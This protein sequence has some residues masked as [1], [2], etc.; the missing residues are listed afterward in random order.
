MYIP[1]KISIDQIVLGERGRSSYNNIE[2]L[3]QSIEDN[4]LIQ[5]LVLVPISEEVKFLKDENCKT[6]DEFAIIGT[7]KMFYGIDAGGRRY[8]A[9]RHLGITELF[10]AT[11]SDPTRPGFVLKGEDQGTPLARLM[12]EIAENLDRLERR[13][14]VAQQGLEVSTC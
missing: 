3:A 12:T 11:T 5:P 4:G 9:L 2:D 13:N 6:E 10:H 8:H 7:G 14:E 1:D